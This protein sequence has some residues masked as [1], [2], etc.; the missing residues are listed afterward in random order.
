MHYHRNSSRSVIMQNI[1]FFQEMC[2][3]LFVVVGKL[4][5][6]TVVGLFIG[7]S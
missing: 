7:P 1:F 3:N 2:S 4:H 5:K 6:L